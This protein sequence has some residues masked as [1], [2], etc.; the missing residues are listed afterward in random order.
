[1][2]HFRTIL[3]VKVIERHSMAFLPEIKFAEFYRLRRFFN[4]KIKITNFLTVCQDM[5]YNQMLFKSDNVMVIS[6]NDLKQLVVKPLFIEF[7]KLKE[8]LETFTDDK[9]KLGNC[10]PVERKMNYSTFKISYSS[11]I[12]GKTLC[13]ILPEEIYAM[14]SLHNT[15]EG[16]K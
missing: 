14:V 7:N 6:E 16:D 9:I 2:F 5:I 3:N 15:V 11:T 8:I 12:S 10:K 4:K 1:M 13:L